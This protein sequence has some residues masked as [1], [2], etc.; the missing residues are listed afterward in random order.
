VTRCPL[1][2]GA[3][4]ATGRYGIALDQCA[5]CGSCFAREG[6]PEAVRSYASDDYLARYEDVQVDAPQRRHEAR[7]RL[8]WMRSHVSGGSLFEAGAAAGHF[9]AE[10][11]SAGFSVS[12]VEPSPT[13]S[14][15][16]RDTHALR[17]DTCLL[18]DAPPGARADVVCLWHVLEH[19]ADPVAML[20]DVAARLVAGG[21]V[22]IEVPNIAS[23]VAPRLRGRWPALAST[24]HLTHFTPAGLTAGLEQA[25]L[26][27]VEVFTI[28][29][30]HY[31][32]PA[33]WASPRTLAS[34]ARDV[35]AG[36][37]VR[38]HPARGDLLRAV[39]RTDG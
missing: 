25:G 27:P 24:E 31:R 2:G 39:A 34:A 6:R 3:L 14:T 32:R 12:G 11:R 9:L 5:A 16:A 26:T 23:P 10:A 17:V 21:H 20:R 13:L 7:L 1:C 37:G 4:A 22:F 28:P 33:A 35:V 8:R 30:W 15:F 19:A 29:R 38:R 36:G 18:E